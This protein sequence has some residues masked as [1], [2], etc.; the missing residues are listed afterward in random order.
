M[1]IQKLFCS[2][3]AVYFVGIKGTGVCAL[4]ELMFNAGMKVSGSDTDEIFYTDEILKELQI[5]YYQG[6]DAAHINNTIDIVI[7]SA[8]Y[9]VETNPELA[10]AVE[11]GIPVLKYTDALGLWSE[12]F[13]STGICGVHGKTTTTA[14]CGALARAAGLPAQI[15]TGSGALDFGGRSTL[16]LGDKYF[17]AETC[18]YRR[19]FLS[20][21]PK[22][23]ILTSV[24]SDHQDYF[25]DYNS[26]RDAFVEYCRLLPP[27]AQLIYCA[28]DAGASEVAE[29]IKKERSGIEFIPYGFTAEGDYKITSFSIENERSV[30]SLA[31]FPGA[32]KMRI[33]GRHQVLNAAAA[34]ALAESIAKKEF[35]ILND[36][37]IRSIKYALEDFKS[38]KRRS[39]ILGEAGGIIFM[40]DYGHHPTAITTT[41]SGIKSFYPERRLIVSFMPHTYTRTSAL[42]DDFATAFNDA[43][44]LFLHKIYSS[45]RENY[46]G[47]VDGKLLYEK[48]QTAR[49]RETYFIEEPDDAFTPLREMLKEGDIFLTLGAGNN[50][51]LG[52]KLLNYYKTL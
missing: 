50:W 16:H 34:I 1:G 14:I 52:K 44:I 19:H 22:R 38:T 11:L 33:P 45:A 43:D 3:A 47:D 31:G 9:S 21:H 4:A 39:E 30:F 37:K 13:D 8:A 36:E 41:L 20:F 32:F 46:S 15:L 10:K 25:P 26:I 17:I 5:P 6:F 48:T 35:G 40:D 7:H 24:E 28:D 27:D 51:Q 2:G 29:I 23:I 18:E 12:R 42:L 49:G